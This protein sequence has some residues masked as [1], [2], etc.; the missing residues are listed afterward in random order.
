MSTK[1]NKLSEHDQ[2][3]EREHRAGV[4]DYV[5]LGLMAAVILAIMLGP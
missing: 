2:A 4:A 5:R 1:T 3:K